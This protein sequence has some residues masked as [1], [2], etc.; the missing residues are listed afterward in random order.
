MPPFSPETLQEFAEMPLGELTHVAD[1]AINGQS[2]DELKQLADLLY[3]RQLALSGLESRADERAGFQ[4]LF[5]AVDVVI[6]DLETKIVQ[7]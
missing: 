1:M 7:R 2:T 5:C 4:E 6:A 3:S